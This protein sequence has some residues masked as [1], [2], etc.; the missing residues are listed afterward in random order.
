MKRKG[1]LAL[2]ALMIFGVFST[3]MGEGEI[4]IPDVTIKQYEIPD[5]EAMAFLRGMGAGW[6]LGNTMDAVD[7]SCVGSDLDIERC[8]C[9]SMTTKDMFA[10]V[11]ERGFGTVRIPVSWH[12]H[13]NEA[14][15]INA[16][17]LERVQQLVDWAL[18]CDLRVI[19]NIHH[20]DR[21]DCIYPDE[22]RLES[23]L[24]YVTAIWSQVAARFAAYDERL[25]FEAMNEPR[26]VGTN[27]EWAFTP[28]SARCREAAECLNRLNQAFVDTVR[29]AGGENASRYLMV[30]GYCAAPANT[31]PS[32]FRLPEDTAENRLIVSTHS[33]IP[34]AF[35]LDKDGVD[36]FDAG[37]PS[38]TREIDSTMDLLYER[39]IRRG[40]PVVMGECGARDKG[41]LQ[42][43]VNWAAYY[44]AS[45][46]ARGIPCLWWDNAAFATSGENFG[47]LDRRAME[48]PFPEIVEALLRYALR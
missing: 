12:N 3:A 27:F 34:Y 14:L 41:N 32:F 42:S 44:A 29:A 11:R 6:N 18:E 46:S 47:L 39:F 13:V 30:P 38:D 2:C 45:A 8:W 7:D 36:A 9:G 48:W 33:Y 4:V 25:L 10:S 15:V 37:R 22:E 28:H 19:V 20:D 21:L 40:V 35:A 31:D 16:P 5:S 26:L 17:W 23:S 43:R 24:R 1:I